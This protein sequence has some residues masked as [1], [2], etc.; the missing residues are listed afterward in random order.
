[1]LFLIVKLIWPSDVSSASYTS[2]FTKHMVAITTKET[3]TNTTKHYRHTQKQL[4]PYYVC[5]IGYCLISVP[6]PKSFP[7]RIRHRQRASLV[8]DV[9]FVI[10]L[11]MLL[12]LFSSDELSEKKFQKKIFLALNFFYVTILSTDVL[13]IGNYNRAY[14][15]PLMSHA[16]GGLAGSR[17]AVVMN[18]ILNV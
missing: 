16:P 9:I 14:S 6:F 3:K 2:L 7:Y 11:Y 4:F 15:E 10:F 1:M 12:T 8:T 17:R 18:A 5:L 13:W